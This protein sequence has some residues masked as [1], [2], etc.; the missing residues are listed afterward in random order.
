MIRSRINISPL[1]L[2]VCVAVLV[3]ASWALA[4]TAP[5]VPDPVLQ[6]PASAP[7][8]AAVP[9]PAATPAVPV[10]A[11]VDTP[12]PSDNLPPAVPTADPS[13]PAPAPAEGAVPSLMDDL[14]KAL[15]SL[16]GDEKKDQ[17]AGGPILP[18]DI[19]GLDLPTENQKTPEQDAAEMRSQSFNAMM[20]GML[21]LNPPEIRDAFGK[22]DENQKAIEEPLAYPKPEVSF[23]TISLDPGAKP[24][25]FKLATGHVTTVSFLDMTGQ[26]W[27]IKDMTWAG[28][29]DVK[30]ATQNADEKFPMYPNIMRIIPM[31]EYAYGNMSVRLVGLQTPLTFTLRTG[32][33]VVQYRLDLRVPQNGPFAVPALMGNMGAN[34]GLTAGDQ[35]LTRILEGVP[36]PAAVRLDVKGVDGRTSAYRVNGNTYVR[37]PYTLLSPAWSGSVRSADGMNVY[38]MGNAPVLLLSDG[39]EMVRAELN[40]RKD[41]SNE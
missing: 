18:T 39:G 41:E 22:M 10:P 21:P 3:P 6:P 17:S 34:T 40:E 26:P 32:R 33:E 37:T 28:N 29:F 38:A 25:T 24:I 20:S 35:I 4:Q 2:C 5:T 11:V 19:P 23:T 30:S 15:P 36:P 16:S 31:S 14:K 9:A 8:P 13:L 7:A 27:P 12:P 1:L